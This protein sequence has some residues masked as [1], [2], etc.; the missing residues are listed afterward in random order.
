MSS[1][2]KWDIFAAHV[3]SY[4]R[5]Q[6]LSWKF[7]GL[8][9]RKASVGGFLS[10]SS[11]PRAQPWTGSGNYQAGV[12][13]LP[14]EEDEDVVWGDYDDVPH[15]SCLPHIFL[16]SSAL[17]LSGDFIFNYNHYNHGISS[18]I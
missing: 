10:P 12:R 3:H 5:C 6:Q 8:I 11:N 4:N 9:G 17:P 15:V 1:W 14:F 7:V 16:I 13:L 18:S 2:I